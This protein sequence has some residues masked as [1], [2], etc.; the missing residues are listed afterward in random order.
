MGFFRLPKD[1]IM[2]M[3]RGK[4]FLNGNDLFRIHQESMYLDNRDKYEILGRVDSPLIKSE[5]ERDFFPKP[6]YEISK[7][8]LPKYEPP[9]PLYE[10]A[11]NL[12]DSNSKNDSQY[13][14]L[15]DILLNKK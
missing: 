14:H 10:K 1:R 13:D 12:F 6:L 15:I 5:L 8:D 4:S 9:K 11:S 7:P 3:T 2:D